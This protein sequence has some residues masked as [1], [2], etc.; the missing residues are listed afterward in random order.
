MSNGDS[1]ACQFRCSA[2]ISQFDILRNGN[3][4]SLMVE[5]NWRAVWNLD[6]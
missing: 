2:S 1:Y 4:S 3:S 6:M 5:A